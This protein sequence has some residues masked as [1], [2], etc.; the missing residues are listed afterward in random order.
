M[1]SILEAKYLPYLRMDLKWVCDEHLASNLS[2][3]E[4]NLII[5]KIFTAF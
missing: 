1:L 2:I 3:I 5:S 4:F